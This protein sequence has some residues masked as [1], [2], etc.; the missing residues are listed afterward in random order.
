MDY[1]TAIALFLGYGVCYTAYV[2]FDG[3]RSRNFST[4]I[5]I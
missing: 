4:V 5:N 1:N 2:I 3:L